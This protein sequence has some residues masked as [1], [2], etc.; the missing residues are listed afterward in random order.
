MASKLRVLLGPGP[1]GGTI[2]LFHCPGCRCSH[3]VEVPRWTWNGSVDKPTFSPSLLCNQHHAESRCHS[4]V[5]D[6]R[7][8]FLTDCHHELAGKTVEIPNW[9]EDSY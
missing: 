6:G 9:D 5:R 1:T 4:F 8:E 2:Y 3:P 7:I